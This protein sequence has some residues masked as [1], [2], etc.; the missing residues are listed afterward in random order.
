MNSFEM[1]RGSET[2]RQLYKR[3]TRRPCRRLSCGGP[4]V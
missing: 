3:P 2:E 4:W 1:E